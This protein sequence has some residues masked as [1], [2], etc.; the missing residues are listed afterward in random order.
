MSDNKPNAVYL[1]APVNAIIEGIYK[2]K[3]TIAQILEH[4][5][6]GLGTFNRLDGEMVVMDG[7]VYQMKADGRAYTVAPDEQ[8]PFACVTRFTPDTLDEF[9]E[10]P[11][12]DLLAL[13]ERIIPSNNMLYAIRVDGTFNHV[14][15]RSVPPQDNYRPLVEVAR[16]QPEFEY[17]NIQGTMVGFHT[18]QFLG[19]VSVPG[20]HLHFL[21]RDTTCGGHL[22]TCDP[23]PITIGIQHVSQLI[24]GLPM[25]LDF[26]TMGFERDTAKDLEEAER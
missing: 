9:P 14:K 17:E 10:S 8:T 2:E 4:G 5:D 13:I 16:E 7:R 24:M 26:L 11:G 20:I 19:G 18:P 25:T 22:L 21:S 1:S 6:F 23:G 12:Q 15:T 3:T